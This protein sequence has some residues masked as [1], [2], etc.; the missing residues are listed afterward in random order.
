MVE[1]AHQLTWILWQRGRKIWIIMQLGLVKQKWSS[2]LLQGGATQMR[3]HLTA[4]C[5]WV[6]PL[7]HTLEAM[8]LHQRKSAIIPP[9]IQ[10]STGHFWSIQEKRW[11]PHKPHFP[12]GYKAYHN[13]L[14]HNGSALLIWKCCFFFFPVGCQVCYSCL[15][16]V[17]RSRRLS[18]WAV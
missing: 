13:T 4:A 3:T 6:S 18:L 2:H 9:K 17:R 16:L 7:D 15:F 8:A 5:W 14:C 1:W 12:D 10:L 11:P